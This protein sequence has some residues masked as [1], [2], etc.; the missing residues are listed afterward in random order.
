MTNMVR[1]QGSAEY[2]ILLAMVL[3]VALIAVILLGGMPIGTGDTMR[4][5]S[6]AY[7]TSVRPFQIPE[8]VQIDGTFFLTITNRETARLIL[9]NISIGNVS[10]VLNPGWT[11]GSGTTRNLS[12]SGFR[13]CN[14]T[15]DEYEYQV[16]ITYS[17]S[18]ISGQRQTGMKPLS[19]RCIYD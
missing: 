11:F 6:V 18:D 2:L 13:P 15:Y 12:I 1:G 4:S 7:W 5:E 16:N 3:I 9:E 19:G 8:W 10:Y 17:T 14:N